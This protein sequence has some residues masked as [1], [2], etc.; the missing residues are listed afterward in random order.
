MNA[1]DSVWVATALLQ[2]E[3]GADAAFGA[4][5]IADRVATEGLWHKAPVTIKT[6]IYQHNVATKKPQ[7]DRHRLL[8]AV[9]SGRRLFRDGSDSFHPERAG[10]KTHPNPAD[11]PEQ[12]RPLVDWYRSTFVAPPE[13]RSTPSPLLR[14]RDLS[15]KL[16]LWK[17]VDA[18]AYVREQRDGW[19]P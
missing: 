8:T 1:A 4:R 12:Y 11:L 10:G 3:Q 17:G 7:P 5:E 18:D 9:G 16:G 14:L 19:G 6:H 2:R 15:R 13:G